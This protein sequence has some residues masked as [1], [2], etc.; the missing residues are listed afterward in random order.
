MAQKLKRSSHISYTRSFT[1]YMLHISF[2]YNCTSRLSFVVDSLLLDLVRPNWSACWQCMASQRAADASPAS[3]SVDAAAAAIV[4]QTLTSQSESADNAVL[5]AP[6]VV[7]SAQSPSQTTLPRPFSIEFT[8]PQEHDSVQS[9]D[10]ATEA[11]PLSS[12]D[13]IQSQTANATSPSAAT[14]SDPVSQDASTSER[15]LSGTAFAGEHT[16][17]DMP[18]APTYQQENQNDSGSSPQ[19]AI[20]QDLSGP[21]LSPKIGVPTSVTGALVSPAISERSIPG[22]PK[23]FSSSLR[24]NKKFLEKLVF[25]YFCI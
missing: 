5:P 6:S 20:D 25:L 14:P 1:L 9:T 10:Q 2:I 13:I 23:K 15:A 19:E 3:S 17:L 8:E 22:Q 11:A 18:L 4:D 12:V 7:A 21:A 16:H 24:V